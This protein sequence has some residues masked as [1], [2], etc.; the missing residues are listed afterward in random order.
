[1]SERALLAAA[2]HDDAGAMGL[3]NRAVEMAARS[4]GNALVLPSM[5]GRRAKLELDLGHPIDAEAD[6][7]KALAIEHK[8]I[9]PGQA[10]GML[11]LTYLALARA[12]AANGERQEAEH[13]AATAAAQLLPTL[14]P[15]H[16]D[17][18]LAERLAASG[19]FPIR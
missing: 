6:A 7:T 16:P 1:M 11:G 5:L 9:A 13:S 14:G 3:A 19:N 10:S 8:S 17:T 12:E 18:R 2:R 4:T 15:D